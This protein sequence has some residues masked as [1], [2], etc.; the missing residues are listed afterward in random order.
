MI[1]GRDRMRL[2]ASPTG[3]AVDFKSR[4]IIELGQVRTMGRERDWRR[5]LHRKQVRRTL[6][7]H[8]SL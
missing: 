4:D 1:R 3:L 7:P 8:H 6:I 2:D 5:G